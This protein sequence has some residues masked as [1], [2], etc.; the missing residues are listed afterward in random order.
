[1]SLGATTPISPRTRS[2]L[3]ALKYATAFP[4]IM[5]S[6]FQGSHGDPF[7]DTPGATSEDYSTFT[8]VG[9]FRIW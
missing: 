9:I 3:N 6:A 5:F 2:L 1:M 4:V 8:K 7:H